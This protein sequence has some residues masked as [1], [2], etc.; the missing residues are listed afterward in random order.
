MGPAAKGETPPP[1]PPAALSVDVVRLDEGFLTDCC[2]SSYGWREKSTSG[3]EPDRRSSKSQAGREGG[4]SEDMDG[5]VGRVAR[6]RETDGS[7][8]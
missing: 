5:G 8:V 2:W 4:W 1:P 7:C 6:G 3:S